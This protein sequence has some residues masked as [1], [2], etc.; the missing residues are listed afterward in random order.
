MRIVNLIPLR[1]LNGMPSQADGAVEN[2]VE[3]QDHSVW[4]S[5]RVLYHVHY[6][7]MDSGVLQR[8]VTVGHAEAS[9]NESRKPPRA[10]TRARNA[11]PPTQA[12]NTT[13]TATAIPKRHK[14][15]ATAC[16]QPLPLPL[17]L[18]VAHMQAVLTAIIC[19]WVASTGGLELHVRVRPSGVDA[20]ASCGSVVLVTTSSCSARACAMAT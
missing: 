20:S 2:G 4:Y 10:E 13:Q 6:I 7:D 19:F 1:V 3:R 14:V 8:D 16:I 11:S 12:N 9:R 17:R 15:P 18:F 5:F